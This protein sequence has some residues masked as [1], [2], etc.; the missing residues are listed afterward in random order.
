MYK[1]GEWESALTPSQTDST[2]AGFTIII[3]YRLP[4]ETALQC[5]G[6]FILG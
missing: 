6:R 4:V 3:S 1:T 5:G 2:F